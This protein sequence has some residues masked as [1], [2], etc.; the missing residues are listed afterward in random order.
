MGLGSGSN[1]EDGD[2]VILDE[3]NADLTLKFED[4]YTISPMSK[5]GFGFMWHGVRATHGV[6]PGTRA[7]FE[8]SSHY[9]I[10][11]FDEN[12]NE[13]TGPFKNISFCYS[14]VNVVLVSIR[15]L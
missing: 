11:N 8:V 4:N 12:L 3:Y 2:K 5:K 14:N 7:V 10:G 9:S 6:G 15:S 13:G 1:L